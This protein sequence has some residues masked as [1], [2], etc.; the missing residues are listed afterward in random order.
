[1]GTTVDV[2]GDPP[3]LLVVGCKFIT[4]GDL[5]RWLK[6][7]PSSA[8]VQVLSNLVPMPSSAQVQVL[9]NLG[10]VTVISK[11]RVT[12]SGAVLLS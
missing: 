1:M 8:Q 12:K 11:M 2:D 9:S 6:D 10:V 4:A 3:E 5:I 7:V